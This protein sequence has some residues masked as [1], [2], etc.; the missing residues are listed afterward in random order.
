MASHSDA[1]DLLTESASN[2]LDVCFKE[3]IEIMVDGGCASGVQL[4]DGRT[5]ATNK[6]IANISPK[7]FY[8]RMIDEHLEPV[9]RRRVRGFRVGPGTFSMNVALSELPDFTCKPGTHLQSH[10]QSGIVTGPTMKYLEQVYVDATQHGWSWNPI[11]EILIPCT[12]DPSLA[13]DGQHVT[14]LFCQQFS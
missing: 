3:V 8:S 14:S 9:F 4:S 1:L 2:V 10:H 12:I 11:V 6:V 5:I 7:L 13:P